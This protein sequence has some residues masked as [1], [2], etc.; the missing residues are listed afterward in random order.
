[1]SGT[2]MNC[3]L[4]ADPH[5]GV[6]DA[7]RGLLSTAFDVVVMVADEISLFESASR[8][9]SELA[10]VDLA[11]SRGNSLDLVR[12]LRSRFPDMKM[13]IVSVDG[14]PSVSRCVMEAGANAFVVKRALATDLLAATDAVRSGQHYVSP[15][16]E[17]WQARPSP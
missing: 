16:V 9:R 1:M 8:L 3:V 17:Q 5:R 11:V 12:R 6:S 13:I 10:V 14:Q 4:L 15:G 2:E 7:V